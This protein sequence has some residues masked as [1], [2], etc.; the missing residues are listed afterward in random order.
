MQANYKIL[1]TEF[2]AKKGFIFLG[3]F[4]KTSAGGANMWSVHRAE[5]SMSVDEARFHFQKEHN[6]QIQR[7]IDED[8]KYEKDSGFLINSVDDKTEHSKQI[9]NG[10]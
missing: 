2:F 3:S 9:L 6:R 1:R 10:L 7:F 4:I 5:R 8:L